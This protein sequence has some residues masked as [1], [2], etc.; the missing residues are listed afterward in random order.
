MRDFLRSLRFL[1]PYRGRIA[2]VAAL[3][4]AIS[5]LWA[6]GLA[7]LLPGAKVLLSDEPQK[8]LPRP[9]GRGSLYHS[10]SSRQ[11]GKEVTPRRSRTCRR[12]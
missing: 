8:R 12:A 6:G 9:G 7:A 11:T 4:A 10:C 1:R 2:L 3:V 5:V